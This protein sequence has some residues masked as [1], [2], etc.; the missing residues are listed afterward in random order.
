MF[1]FYGQGAG[2]GVPR[3]MGSALGLESG[4]HRAFSV[5]LG[6]GVEGSPPPAWGQ[7]SGQEAGA[8]KGPAG[9]VP[10]GDW[11]EDGDD[12]G[13]LGQGPIGVVLV[14]GRRHLTLSSLS[15]RGEAR[16]AVTLPGSYSGRGPRPHR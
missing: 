4:G 12:G 6:P 8:Q 16:C 5:T 14:D 13:P 10:R 2:T 7:R 15:C 9:G 3:D 1:W 11:P